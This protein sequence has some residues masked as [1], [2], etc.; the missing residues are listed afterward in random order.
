M[1]DEDR[2]K[3]GELLIRRG[4]L[5][6]DQLER[7]LRLQ[8]DIDERIGVILVQRGD[9]AE[10]DVAEALARALRENSESAGVSWR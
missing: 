4:R 10:R 2:R 8:N 1:S 6:P 7:A 3:L 9:V 5:Q